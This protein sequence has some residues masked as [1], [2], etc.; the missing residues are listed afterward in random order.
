[1]F[2]YTKSLLAVALALVAVICAG[3]WVRSQ[4]LGLRVLTQTRDDL[5]V[6]TE[7]C[8]AYAALI[9]NYEKRLDALDRD[10]KSMPRKFI[11]RDYESSQLVKAV[12]KS[13]SVAGMEM[14]NAAKREQRTDS[15]TFY[16]QGQKAS[17]ITHE[18]ILH[19]SYTGLVKFMQSL[20]VWD[21]G[22]RLESIEVVPV[23]AGT[24]AGEIEATL[25]LSVFSL[26]SV[27]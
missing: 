15:L 14:T 22:Y 27:N 20:T 19:G 24:Q 10:I 17:V 7:G 18:I 26:E 9:A 3:L 8:Q 2:S 1:M 25:I 11:G 16:G 6:Q 23:Q 12:V 13:A 21:L 5:K 4:V